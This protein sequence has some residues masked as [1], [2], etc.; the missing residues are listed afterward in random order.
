MADDYGIGYSGPSVISAFFD[1]DC[2][3]DLDLYILNSSFTSRMS[4][5]YRPKINDGSS[6]NNDRLVS[7]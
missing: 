4:T 2:D 3:G 5:S 6:V 1:Y 7:E